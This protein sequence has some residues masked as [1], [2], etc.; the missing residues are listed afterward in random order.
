MIVLSENGYVAPVE[1]ISELQTLKGAELDRFDMNSCAEIEMNRT[2]VS[3]DPWNYIACFYGP[4][5]QDLQMTLLIT[6]INGIIFVTGVLGNIAVCIVIIKQPILH[7][8]TNYYLFNLAVS[9]VT[10]LIFGLPND[11][12]MYWHQYPWPLGIFFCKFRALI[13]ETASYVSVLTVVAFSTERYIAIC[14][15]LYLRAISGLQRAVWIIAG[16]WIVSFFCALPFAAYTVITYVTYPYNSTNIV[17]ESAMCAMVN[18]PKNIPLTELSSL[19]FFIVPTVI[20][21]VL[22]CNMGITIAKASRAKFENKVK[23]SIHRK[24]K[25]HQSNKSI[26][27]M[28]SL[29][30]LGFF[31]CWAP[32]HAQRLMAIYFRDNEIIEYVNYWMF[33]ITGICYYFSSTLNPI[34][35]NVMSEKMRNAFKEI[36]CGIKPKKA[37]KRGTFRETSNTYVSMPNSQNNHHSQDLEEDV[38]ISKDGGTILLGENLRNGKK[39]THKTYGMKTETG[40]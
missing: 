11:V 18:Q 37:L 10:L 38:F 5:M 2:N 7:T 32:F 15:P 20:I 31:M 3:L 35:Y 39:F 4:Q 9:D 36:F 23:G 25:K 19:I 1:N 29:V 30:V 21:A 28:L 40:V 34:L 14:Y 22:Y 27:R 33:F 26:I 17:E 13:S 12:A 16:L 8:A 6:I 24:N